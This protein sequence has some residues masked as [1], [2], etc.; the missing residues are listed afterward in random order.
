MP[1]DPVS[2][3]AVVGAVGATLGPVVKDVLKRMA[4]PAADEVGA[5]LGEKVRSYRSGNASAVAAKAGEMLAAVGAEPQP[6][7]LRLLLPALDAASLEDRAQMQERWAALLANASI[8][9]Q[10]MSGYPQMLERLS[11]RDAEVLATCGDI[12]RSV[13]FAPRDARST[14]YVIRRPELRERTSVMAHRDLEEVIDTLVAMRLLDPEPALCALTADNGAM[15]PVGL[16]MTELGRAFL[17][18]VSPPTTRAARS[19]AG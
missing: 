12:D 14:A 6:V 3:V 13:L 19:E 4:G 9:V 2:T 5:W 10:D 18:A 7:P 8:G 17:R 11:P 1:V 16:R 15:D